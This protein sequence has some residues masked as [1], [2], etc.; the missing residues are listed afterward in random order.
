[1]LA[2]FF[3]GALCTAGSLSEFSEVA[4]RAGYTTQVFELDTN[5]FT[6][7]HPR[8]L[9]R[10]RDAIVG[11][12]SKDPDSTRIYFGYSAGSKF[13]AS[14][15]SEVDTAVDGL[16]LLDPVDGPPPL[17]KN[18]IRF[19]VFLE[20]ISPNWRQLRPK[21]TNARQS[22]FKILNTELGERAGFGGVPCVSEKYGHRWFARRMG[23]QANE[24]FELKE[25]GHLDPLSRQ[26]GFPGN[27][28]CPAGS[29]DAAREARERAL[30]QFS[31]FLAEI[32]F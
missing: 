26:P 28:A 5:P 21:E 22:V 6:A 1:M 18:F 27:M 7:N 15:A 9:T 17:Q 29:K 10:Y 13:A 8:D 14:L 12:I 20:N 4:A 23:A 32:D 25:A 19:P 2:F 3:C 16:F 11:A 24:T 30:E 31:Q